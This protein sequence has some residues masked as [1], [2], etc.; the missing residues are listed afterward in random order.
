MRL[1][2]VDK[3]I[4]QLNYNELPPIQENYE[5]HYSD[6]DYNVQSHD[7]RKIPL[8]EDAMKLLPDV[9]FN[10]ELKQTDDELKREVLKLI[11]KYERESITI[12]GS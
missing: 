8:L 5:L 9:P 11:R 4:S 3:D 6:F 1:C 12:W 7:D 10:M 2:G